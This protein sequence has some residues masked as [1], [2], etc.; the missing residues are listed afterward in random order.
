MN[1]N[2]AIWVA[3]ISLSSAAELRLISTGLIPL[4]CDIKV[5]MGGIKVC[6][7]NSSSMLNYPCPD[8]GNLAI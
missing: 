5:R 1:L 4:F 2:L 7:L 6:R 3:E 8:I